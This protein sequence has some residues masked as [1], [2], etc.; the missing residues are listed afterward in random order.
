L[1]GE[2]SL[3]LAVKRQLL[4]REHAVHDLQA[5]LHAGLALG[6]AG[7]RE[8]EG[9]LVECLA[10]ADAEHETA[11]GQAVGGRGH[12]RDERRVVVEQ[13]AGDRRAE[14][15]VVRRGGD[16]AEPGPDKACRRRVVD[17]GVE[18]VA[19]EHD[20]EPG[21]LGGHGLLDQVFGLVGLVAA[22]PGELHYASIVN[23]VTSDPLTGCIATPT[24]LAP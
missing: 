10:G 23:R 20:V 4:P 9:A 17:P 14:Q 1:G 2:Y 8:A 21:L 15:H 13:R 24:R 7:E 12:L 5:L 6:V 3:A 19:A 18:V 16:R 11:V 22:Q